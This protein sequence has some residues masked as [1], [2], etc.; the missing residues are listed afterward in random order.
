MPWVPIV[1]VSALEGVNVSA[2]IDLA[3]Q[4]NVERLV[5]IPTRKLWELLQ[6]AL[7]RRSAPSKGHLKLR[8][9]FVSQAK[10][11]TPTFVFFVNEVGTKKKEF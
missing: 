8:I 7:M 11:T 10:T 3:I 5:R 9:G 4:V 6:R 2:V 1:F